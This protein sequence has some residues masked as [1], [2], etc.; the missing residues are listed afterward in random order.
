VRGQQ[1]QSGGNSQERS[2]FDI[3]TR[4]PLASQPDNRAAKFDKDSRLI[5]C[6]A[7][8]DIEDGGYQIEQRYGLATSPYTFGVGGGGMYHWNLL[9]RELIAS[10]NVLYALSLVGGIQVPQTIGPFVGNGIVHYLQMSTVPTV[11][12]GTGGTMPYN[13]LTYITNGT[14]LVQVTDVNFPL[15]TVPGF[16]FLDGTTYV[17]TN[18]GIIYGSLNLNDPTL[19]DPLN[20]IRANSYP[21]FAIYLAQQLT[22]VVALKEWSTQFFYDAGNATGSPLAPVPGAL[23]NYGCLSADTVQEIDGLLLWVTSSK[24][25]SSQVLLLENL[26]MTIVSTPGIDRQLGLGTP[27]SVFRSWTLKRGGHRL[28]CITNIT[29]NVSMVYDIDQKLW[30]QWTDYLGNYYPIVAIVPDQAGNLLAQN[31]ASSSMYYIDTDFVYPN[32]AGQII[33]VDIYTPNFDADV[34][35]VKMLSQMRFNADQVKGSLLDVRF[36]EDD[37]T[38][39]TNF[40]RVNL[41]NKRPILSDCGS[42]YR[43]AYHFRQACNTPFRIESVDLQMG[44]GTL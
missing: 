2:G 27:L 21:D 28:Y 43:R 3:P 18:T 41:G 19:W 20:T 1:Q 44:I 33:T 39:W 34:D 24:T 7:E 25:E 23:L 42:F 26:A 32:D 17:M 31:S 40:R 29:S 5:N 37:Y 16:V 30:Y 11:I 36:S 8:R 35:R 6:Y 38:N 14:S 12:F 22:Y 9:F 4:W 10:G 15:N 13:G